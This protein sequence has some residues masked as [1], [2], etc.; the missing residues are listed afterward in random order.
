MDGRRAVVA[1]GVGVA[2]VNSRHSTWTGCHRAAQRQ[3]TGC[4]AQDQGF[5][6]GVMSIT[7]G[8]RRPR[9]SA[10]AAKPCRRSGISSWRWANAHSRN[11]EFIERHAA[12][13]EVYEVTQ[14]WNS[15]SGLLILP[16]EREIRTLEEVSLDAAY[17]WGW[18]VI[19]VVQGPSSS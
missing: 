12:S 3:R 17:R 14:L 9:C 8:T 7:N 18:P 19:D 4:S 16:Q 13:Q 2:V 5:N 10:Y 11:L 6:I 1:L 15:L